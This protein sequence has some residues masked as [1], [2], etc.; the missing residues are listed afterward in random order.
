MNSFGTVGVISA[1]HS[2]GFACFVPESE[3]DPEG[4]T[5]TYH[6]G[7]TNA[8]TPILRCDNHHGVY[9]RHEGEDVETIAFPGYEE[10]L[11]RFSRELPDEVSR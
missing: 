10:L 9:E 5:Y 1:I 3:T 4:M 8:D 7:E 6:H 11:G 2:S